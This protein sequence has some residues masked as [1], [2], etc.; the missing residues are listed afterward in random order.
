MDQNARW[1]YTVT[2]YCFAGQT[3]AEAA[4]TCVGAGIPGIEGAPPLVEGLDL[5]TIERLGTDFRSAGLSIPSFHLPFEARHDVASFYRTLRSKA[6]DDLKK[7]IARA[8]ALGAEV[9]ILH[10]STSRCDAELEGVDGF[11]RALEES[12]RELLPFAAEHQ[13]LIALENMLPG[14]GGRFGSRPDHFRR[15]RSELAHPALGFCLDTGHALVAG[16]PEGAHGFYEAMEGRLLAFHLSDSAGDRDMHIAP[17]RGLVDWRRL[18][19]AASRNGFS[20]AMCIETAPF[21]HAVRDVYPLEAWREHIRGVQRLADEALGSSPRA[22][23]AT[24]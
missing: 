21:A 19:Q 24:P 14:D 12:L 10:P 20:R 13:L 22:T 9:A 2:G 8:A 18:F 11:L 3:L 16:G 7:W 1:T 5:A 6:V 15:I 4:R 17:G 23:P